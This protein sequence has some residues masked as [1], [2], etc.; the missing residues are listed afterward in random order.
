MKMKLSSHKNDC[1]L[2][3]KLYIAY[4]TRDGNLDDFF[5][6]ENQTSPPSVWNMGELNSGTKSKL[7]SHLE[8]L[9]A[10][11][12]DVPDI[13]AVI[14]IDGAVVVNILATG[15]QGHST[16]NHPEKK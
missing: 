8:S 3:S 12:P 9:V 11:M 15:K 14:I 1:S 16:S 13:K 4:Q 5:T 6:R 2:F 10:P 7:V